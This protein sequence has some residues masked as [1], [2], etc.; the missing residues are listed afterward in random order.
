M[1][2]VKLAAAA[3]SVIVPDDPLTLPTCCAKPLR[4]NVPPAMVKAVVLVSALAT[5][6]LTVPE[7]NVVAPVLELAPV[8]V[9]V[10]EPPMVKPRLPVKVP[11]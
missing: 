4:S 5:P 11:A 10:P 2:S 3:L 7:F 9:K 8:N 6:T 1:L